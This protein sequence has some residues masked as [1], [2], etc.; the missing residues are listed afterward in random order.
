MLGLGGWGSHHKLSE[1]VHSGLL[2]CH[3]AQGHHA[4]AEGFLNEA[5]ETALSLADCDTKTSY[6]DVK[7]VFSTLATSLKEQVMLPIRFVWL[8]TPCCFIFA[9]ACKGDTSGRCVNCC[10]IHM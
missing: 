2:V 1:R 5:F 8:V 6:H 7:A 10:F 4:K 3:V 9:S